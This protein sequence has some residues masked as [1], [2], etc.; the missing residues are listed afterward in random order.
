MCAYVGEEVN[1]T[2]GSNSAITVYQIPENV[3][4]VRVTI[5]KSAVDTDTNHYGIFLTDNGTVEEIVWDEY[6]FY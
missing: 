5:A 4:K 2:L 3:T 6:G 1:S